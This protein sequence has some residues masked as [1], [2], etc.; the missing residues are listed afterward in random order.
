MSATARAFWPLRLPVPV[1]ALAK[2][3]GALQPTGQPLQA[4][5][6]AHAPPPD[7]RDLVKEISS[8]TITYNIKQRKNRALCAACFNTRQTKAAGL[9]PWHWSP[10]CPSRSVS[11]HTVLQVSPQLSSILFNATL[12]SEDSLQ[13]PDGHLAYFNACKHNGRPS[14]M[15]DRWS[16]Y[17]RRNSTHN[18]TLKRATIRVT[19]AS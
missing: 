11:V 10:D 2:R 6:G 14:A 4:A 7:E 8:D 17:N 16:D 15:P 5:A 18:S 13:H 3:F 19:D 1:A 12:L 9:L